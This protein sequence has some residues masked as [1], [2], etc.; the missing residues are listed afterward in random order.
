MPAFFISLTAACEQLTKPAAF[1]AASDLLQTTAKTID[2]ETITVAEVRVITND[3]HY[4][5]NFEHMLAF[6]SMDKEVILKKLHNAKLQLATFE[7]E[8]SQLL[9]LIT[10]WQRHIEGKD[11]SEF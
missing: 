5:N 1:L 9:C 10:R 3:L 7:R 6:L 2:E 4:H 8:R 11:Q